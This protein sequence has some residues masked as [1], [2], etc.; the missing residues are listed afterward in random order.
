MKHL[1]LCVLLPLAVLSPGIAHADQSR[2]QAVYR[3]DFQSGFDHHTWTRYTGVP[4]CCSSTIWAP[5]HVVTDANGLDLVTERDPLYGDRWVSAGTSMPHAN[6]LYGKWSVRFRMDAG[7]GVGMCI[8]LWPGHGWPPEIDF[9]EESSIYGNRHVMT[10]TFHHGSG[11]IQNHARVTRDF[12]KWHVMS[13]EW[14]PGKL[15]YLIDGK[16]WHT[17]TGSAVPHQPM[18]LFM[19]TN[20]GSNGQSGLMPAATMRRHVDL[21]VDWVHI[22][23]MRR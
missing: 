8:S 9:A 22:Y 19:Q 16:R 18:H 7:D 1:L 14:T 13:V 12:S 23:R 11:N 17:I 4:R 6:Q 20:V 3:S 15:V 5:S 10:G 21:Q 2:W